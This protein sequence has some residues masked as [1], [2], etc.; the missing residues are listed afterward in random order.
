MI[1][2]QTYSKR[3]ELFLSKLESK[4]AII[5]A[6]SLVTHHADCEHAFRQ[7]SDFWYLTGF[8]EPEA[9]ALFLPHKPKGE[10]YILFVLPKQEEAEVW[11]G[12][13]WGT[14]G[15][16]NHFGADVSHPLEDF[17]SQL[18]NYLQGAN[19]IV[20]RIGKHPKIEPLVLK[21]WAQQLD[22]AP[23]SGSA[24]FSLS[25]PCPY[26]HE[27]RLRKEPEEISRLKEAA[28]ISAAAHEIARQSAKPGIHERHIQGIIEQY[29]LSK[30]A[31]GPAYGSIVAGG[32]NACV[33]HY[34]N[35]SSVLRDGDLV[36]IDAGCSLVDYYNGDI[37]RTFPVNGKFTGEQRAIYEIVLEA[38]K[39]AIDSVCP[40]QT[41]ENIHL[42]A[43]RVLVGGLIDLKLLKGDVDT[44]IE[45]KDYMHLYMHR[46]GHWLG[47]DV[48]DVG[49]YRLGDYSLELE[50]SMVLTV[51][52][53]LYISDRIPTPKDQPEIHD[54]WKGIGIRIED[55]IVVT[56]NG[57]E[58]LSDGALKEIDDMERNLY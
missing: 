25:A 12:F 20:F 41:A 49:S 3:R 34:T 22:S 15:A 27:L 39:S 1:D 53:G 17:S 45:R 13:R 40:G 23:R 46:T 9:V 50:E 16:V 32:D 14:N 43:L 44:V 30:G 31:I 36:L 18:V 7:N 26:L 5:P 28:C 42:S 48:H 58:V 54:R 10:Q 51:E 55:D 38:Q 19:G 57:I 33:L 56:S 4:A 37:T 47:L 2:L 29:F 6:S 8:N 24:A 35:N 21:A 11:N 52:P